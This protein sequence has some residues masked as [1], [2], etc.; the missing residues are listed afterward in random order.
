VLLFAVISPQL[1]ST[2]M[3]IKSTTGHCR[4]LEQLTTA[5]TP[6]SVEFIAMRIVFEA[7]IWS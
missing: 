6:F 5:T 2:L 7:V 1:Y 4:S 3:G